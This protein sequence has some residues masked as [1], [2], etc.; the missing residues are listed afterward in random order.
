MARERLVAVHRVMA[1]EESVVGLKVSIKFHTARW[2]RTL[3]HAYNVKL[4][5]GQQSTDT[6]IQLPIQDHN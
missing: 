3:K 4:L 1:D 5:E 2:T 6:Q